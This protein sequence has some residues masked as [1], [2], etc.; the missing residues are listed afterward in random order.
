MAGSNSA[1]IAI[2][3][4]TAIPVGVIFLLLVF[5]VL[6]RRRRKA[7]WTDI[8]SQMHQLAE[9]GGLAKPREI[10]RATLKLLPRELG[11]GNFGIVY[12]G[13]LQESPIAPAFMVAVKVFKI[14]PAILSM[15]QTP[16]HLLTS[17]LCSLTCLVNGIGW[18]DF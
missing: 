9:S 10:D 13:M 8:L 5:V 12:K 1:I 14:Q 11:R 3:L 18:R 6:C 15:E 4:E 7:S 16:S 17:I 2:S